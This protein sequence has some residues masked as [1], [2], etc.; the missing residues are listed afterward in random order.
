MFF[1]N[2][3]KVNY[4]VKNIFTKTIDQSI[5]PHLKNFDYFENNRILA[6]ILNNVI[7]F[8]FLLKRKAWIK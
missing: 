4:E 8:Y 2:Y 6:T 7:H 5:E 3:K 1:Q